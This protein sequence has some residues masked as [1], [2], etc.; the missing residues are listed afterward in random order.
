MRWEA[1]PRLSILAKCNCKVP[2]KWKRET[3]R[4]EEIHDGRGG[5][6]EAI[7]GFE[8]EEATC[9]GKR[10]MSRSWKRQEMDSPLGPPEGTQPCPHLG[11][12][13]V[14]PPSGFWPPEQ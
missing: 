8:D 3:A 14:R 6:S 2:Y 7:A 13:P 10:A 9:W 4:S 12:I 11:F 5:L 1:H